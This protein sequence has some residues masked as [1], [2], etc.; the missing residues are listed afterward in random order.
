MRVMHGH[1]RRCALR[2]RN[3]FFHPTLALLSAY[4]FV[5]RRQV[6]VKEKI[7]AGYRKDVGKDA[8]SPE[9]T[10][11]GN[12]LWNHRAAYKEMHDIM[13]RLVSFLRS[14]V[15]QPIPALEDL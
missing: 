12:S 11:G 5:L 2:Q 4:L 9:L 7:A 13:F 1:H 10:R 15:Y 14:A 6:I 8:L 3:E